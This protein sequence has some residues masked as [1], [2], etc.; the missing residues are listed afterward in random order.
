MSVVIGLLLGVLFVWLVVPG[1]RKRRK[2]KTE[3]RRSL[4]AFAFEIVG[5]SHYQAALAKITGGI[6][7]DGCDYETIASIVLENDNPHDS[8][9]VRVDIEGHTV[10]YFAREDARAYRKRLAET[11]HPS[12]I[13]TCKAVI[14][15]G[16]DR[17][18]GDEGMF[19]VKLDLPMN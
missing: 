14:R 1:R 7:R 6:S 4:G 11:G 12:S 17:G 5:E 16:W 15:G 10:G 13:G 18:N 19:G 9:A 2:S 8:Q 3:I